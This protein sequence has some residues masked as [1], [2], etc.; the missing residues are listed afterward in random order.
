M[1][2]KTP[3][4]EV[5]KTCLF[6]DGKHYK[7]EYSNRGMCRRYPPCITDDNETG[8]LERQPIVFDRDWCGEYLRDARI[9]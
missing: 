6:Y 3:D 7:A 8:R 5:C 1:V 2:T 9:T 4:P